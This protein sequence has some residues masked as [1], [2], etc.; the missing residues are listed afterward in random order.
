MRGSTVAKIFLQFDETVVLD[1]NI[2]GNILIRVV[3][4]VYLVGKWA[5]KQKWT[6]F[7]FYGKK[8]EKKTFIFHEMFLKVCEIIL[9]LDI[10]MDSWKTL[11]HTY[12]EN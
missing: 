4:F 6:I 12:H 2:K 10:H 5:N 7:C 1:W 3:N 9:K 11:I 8:G